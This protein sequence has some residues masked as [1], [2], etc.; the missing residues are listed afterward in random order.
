VGDLAQTVPGHVLQVKQ[1]QSDKI[2]G[3]PQSEDADAAEDGHEARIHEG[4]V[5]VEHEG[6]VDVLGNP[7]WKEH[8]ANIL[9]DVQAPIPAEQKSIEHEKKL[10]DSKIDPLPGRLRRLEVE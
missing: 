4:K 3:A 9:L 7:Q 8:R 5:M 10:Y 2:C 6:D 1:K